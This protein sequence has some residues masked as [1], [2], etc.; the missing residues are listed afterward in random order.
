ML[1]TWPSFQ[2]CRSALWPIGWRGL[3]V[4]HLLEICI[5]LTY[6]L[7]KALLENGNHLARCVVPGIG[8]FI[9]CSVVSLMADAGEHG[10][11]QL[12]DK[13]RLAVII[14]PSQAET[15]QVKSL[16]APRPRMMNI[17]SNGL[18]VAPVPCPRAKFIALRIS[19]GAISPESGSGLT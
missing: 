17:A 10:Q 18:A 12:A 13:A 19:G 5:D 3:Q 2:T 14:E 1:P 9:K 8:H 7:D 4:C 11:R 6:Q 15:S 16:T